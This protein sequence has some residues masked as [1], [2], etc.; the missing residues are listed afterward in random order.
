MTG[1]ARLHP[2]RVLAISTA[3]F[4]GAVGSISVFQFTSVFV[5]QY[6]G[7]PPWQFATMTVVGGAFGIVGN[8]VAGRL[9][10]RFGR[11]RVGAVSGVCFPVFATL[12]YQAPGW[13]LPFAWIGFVFCAGAKATMLRAFATEL[14][15][16][17]LRGSAMGVAEVLGTLGAATG[18]FVLGLGTQ[19]AGN[20]ADMASLLSVAVAFAGV[21]MLVLPE[22]RGRE[23]EALHPEDSVAS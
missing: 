13:A 3:A 20:L 2:G 6:H 21:V 1:F 16:T 10:D 4:V 7:W 15:P 9:G 8:I 5:R 12:F 11:R 19:Q 17:A 14:F 23:L 18:L 22:T